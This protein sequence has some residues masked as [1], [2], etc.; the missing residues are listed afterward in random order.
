MT[1]RYTDYRY[2]TA[3]EV[4]ARIQADFLHRN[5]TIINIETMDTSQH[6]HWVRIWWRAG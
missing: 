6:G 1:I 2:L 5:N 4:L 3:E